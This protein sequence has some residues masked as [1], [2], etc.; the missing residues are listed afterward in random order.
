MV[1]FMD[2]DG[3]KRGRPV[4]LMRQ[5]FIQDLNPA[6]L[7]Q[8]WCRVICGFGGANS[9]SF[10]CR[11]FRQQSTSRSPEQNLEEFRAPGVHGGP[12]P[13]APAPVGMGYSNRP[14]TACPFTLNH[15]T[16][17]ELSAV[18]SSNQGSSFQPCGLPF[19]CTAIQTGWPTVS[20]G[21]SWARQS[22]P[23]LRDA[24]T[25]S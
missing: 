23:G 5:L 18:P 8:H 17:S 2:T 15:R 22:R 25:S 16:P 21:K 19:L 3:R 12:G 6:I 13:C 14:D 11:L 9:S 20:D 4:M 10:L 7:K 1:R 24:G